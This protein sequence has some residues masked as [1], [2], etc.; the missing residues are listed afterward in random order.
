MTTLDCS[1]FLSDWYCSSF[2]CRNY[3][4]GGTTLLCNLRF[5]GSSMSYC[6]YPDA[7]LNILQGFLIKKSQTHLI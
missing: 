6:S 3:R 1:F 5:L 4:A 2:Q 7:M